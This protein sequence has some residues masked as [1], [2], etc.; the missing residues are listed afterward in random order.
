[1][2][3][4]HFIFLLLALIGTANLSFAASLCAKI[5]AGSDWD[6]GV[7]SVINASGVTVMTTGFLSPGQDT[8]TQHFDE[9]EYIVRFT[10]FEAKKSMSYPGISGCMTGPYIFDSKDKVSM[11]FNDGAA[12]FNGDKNCSPSKRS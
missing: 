8:C 5:S 4:S 6:G 2:K 11:V 3:K 7:F 9:G 10:G 1:M 12:P